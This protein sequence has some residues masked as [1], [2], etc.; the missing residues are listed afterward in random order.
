MASKDPYT[1]TA[2]VLQPLVAWLVEDFGSIPFFLATFPIFHHLCAFSVLS[3][4]TWLCSAL[5]EIFHVRDQPRGKDIV[6]LQCPLGNVHKTNV[7]FK[8]ETCL[9]SIFKYGLIN[10]NGGKNHA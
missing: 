3:P 8:D 1:P 4:I 7:R 6:H 9:N 5:Y 2:V 10:Q